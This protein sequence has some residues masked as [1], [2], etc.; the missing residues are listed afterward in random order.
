MR[1][2]HPPRVCHCCIRYSVCVSCPISRRWIALP[3]AFAVT[4]FVLLLCAKTINAKDVVTTRTKDTSNIMSVGVT[5]D[6]TSE[7]VDITCK[8]PN[9]CNKTYQEPEVESLLADFDRD[10]R[11]EYREIQQIKDKL[12]HLLDTDDSGGLDLSELKIRAQTDHD[13]DAALKKL[14]SDHDTVISWK[15]LDER[16]ESVGAEMTVAEVADWVAYA[17]QL[18]QYS[19]VFRANSISGYTF[20]LLMANDGARLQEVGVYSELHRRQ[21][22]MFLQMKYLGMGRKPEAALS[23]IC[24]AEGSTAQDKKLL[25][26]AWVPAEETPQR[27]QLQRRSPGESTWITVYTGADTEFL[28]V[29]EPREH[30]I[31]RL[32]T[33]NSYGRSP[34]TYVRC[35]DALGSAATSSLAQTLPSMSS[36]GTS[37]SSYSQSSQSGSNMN[38]DAD[39][40]ND[41]DEH[42]GQSVWGLLKMYFWWLDDAIVLLVMVMLP[43]RGII[44][45]D[46]DSLLRLLRRL[47]PNMPSRVTVEVEPSKTTV[48]NAAAR[49]SWE[50]PVDNGVPIVCYTVRWTRTKTEEEKWI[51]LLAVPLPTTVIV[52]KLHHGETY[53]FVVQA[54]NKF[55]LVTSSSR[56]T[57]MVPV[58]E[59]KGKLRPRHP[60]AK[61]RALRNQ[62]YICHDPKCKKKVPFSATLDRR[63]LHYCCLCDREF[64]HY[65]K[66]EVFHTKALSCPIVDGRCICRTCKENRLRRTVTY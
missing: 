1:P 8:K 48:E 10:G 58:P 29:V 30:V 13:V 39:S 56:S 16:W 24:T 31:Y 46:A 50:K 64:C 53:K 36:S 2:L 22:A 52:D 38:S 3:K 62:C 66:G 51:K 9:K 35:E 12:H 4:A 34:R 42:E 37:R 33:W 49:V 59:L 44:Y 5:T 43:I 15:E 63:I 11:V 6:G 41:N 25:Q 7:D 26:I 18:P 27:Y 14:D 45:G 54:T 40:S 60:P 17:V 28:D 23:S 65:H 47:P 57:Y 32:T 55:G 21:L 61:T 20:P 19:D